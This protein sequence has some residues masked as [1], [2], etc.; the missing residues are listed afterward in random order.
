MPPWHAAIGYSARHVVFCAFPSLYKRNDYAR[1]RNIARGTVTQAFVTQNRSAEM[2]GGA[3]EFY[4][5]GD[6]DGLVSGQILREDAL[7]MRSVSKV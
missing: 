5:S 1:G 2:H 3:L 7:A 6:I 4:K